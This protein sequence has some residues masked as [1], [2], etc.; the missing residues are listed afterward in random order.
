M[1]SISDQETVN[2]LLRNQIRWSRTADAL[3]RRLD[4]ARLAVLVLS[5]SGT[6][7]ATLT[8][9]VLRPPGTVPRSV[10]AIAAVALALAA[11]LTTQYLDPAA[12]RRW[13]RTRAVSEG[14][15]VLLFKFRT[16]AAPFTGTDAATRLQSE[17]ADLEDAATDLMGHLPVVELTTAP[18]P[19]SPLG[20]EDYI[21]VRVEHQIN[22][23]YRPKAIHY[24]VLARRLRIVEVAFLAS[25]AAVTAL[26][27]FV[28]NAPDD[29]T[30]LAPWAAALTSLGGA[31]A[32][33]HAT[34][35]Y[36]VLVDSYTATAN[37]LQ[38]R[39]ER[40]R[41]DR[42]P[43]DEDKWSKFV[44]DCEGVIAAENQSWVARWAD[45]S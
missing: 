6:V 30:R 3:K 20:P 21:R 19:P 9:T 42:S 4:R 26:N 40:W 7:A 31:L 35:R 1:T 37:R 25:A 16:G 22:D 44:D 10:A 39:V 13:A 27:G 34:R 36:E 5:A 12:T 17:V 43:S 33:H 23:Y 28:V 38:R 18:D 8:A 24:M 2:T 11:I 29:A 41:A 45:P 32:A 15:K 14:I